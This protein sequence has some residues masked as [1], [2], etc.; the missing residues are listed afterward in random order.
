MCRVLA[1]YGQLLSPRRTHKHSSSG[2]HPQLRHA[3]G[4]LPWRLSHH[5]ARPDPAPGAGR[6]CHRPLAEHLLPGRLPVARP[7]GLK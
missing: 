4:Q 3:A 2:Y 5:H 7:A 6:L 1:S